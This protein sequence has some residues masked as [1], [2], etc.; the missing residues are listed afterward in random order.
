MLFRSAVGIPVIG[1][2]NCIS[3]GGWMEY[4]RK[5]QEAGAD[6]LE[7]NLYF[8]PTNPNLDAASI[9]KLYFDALQEVK[10]TVTI[11][12]AVKLSPYFTNLSQ[13]I[14]ALDKK[15]ANGIALFNR[16][17]QPDLNLENLSVEPGV[18]LS[19]SSDL[20]L[21]LRWIAIMYGKVNASLAG[22]GGV[23]TASDALKMIAAGADVAHLC[24]A[25]LKNGPEHLGKMLKEMEE[26]LVRKEY[27]SLGQ[28][29][30]SLSQKS[31]AEPAEFERANYM[32]AIN[33]YR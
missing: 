22:T 1:S 33:D 10:K 7:L 25:I 9:E 12:I 27:K 23:H 11:P 31:V 17:Y 5:L 28:L 6:A 4:S 21:P 26:W 2:L 16:F 32:K 13:M 19:N 30:G 18:V 20:R 24:A 3:V 8:I 29:K 15:G 14:T